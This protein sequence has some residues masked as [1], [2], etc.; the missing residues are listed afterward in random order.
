MEI[1]YLKELE[2]NPTLR[3]QTIKP[4]PESEISELEQLYNDGKE[5]PLALRE[6][7]FLAG[8]YCYVLDYGIDDT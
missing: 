5:F 6:L 1:K 4:I 2:L 8:S 7:L 3:N